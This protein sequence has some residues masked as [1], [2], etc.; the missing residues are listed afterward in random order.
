MQVV[1]AED[2]YSHTSKMVV[3][4][5]LKRQFGSAGQKVS[6]I[7]LPML[8]RLQRSAASSHIIEAMHAICNHTAC[9]AMQEARALRFLRANNTASQSG[10]VKLSSAFT[11][12][13][14]VCL[15]LERLYGSL[16]DYVVHSATLHKSQVLHHLRK[17]AMQLLVSPPLLQEPLPCAPCPGLLLQ[18][19]VTLLLMLLPHAISDFASLGSDCK[20]VLLMNAMLAAKEPK[21]KK[22]AH[23]SWV[24]NCASS[25]CISFR[26][27]PKH[28]S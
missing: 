26:L 17:I 28:A 15:A 9:H 20:G 24:I 18:L 1:L 27:S 5:I 11:Y 14:H 16:L 12:C 19:L 7:M 13:G 2:T 21:Q 8:P 22:P 3:I 25:C 10:L 6:T 23:V 4:K